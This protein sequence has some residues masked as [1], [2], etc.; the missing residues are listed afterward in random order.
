MGQRVVELGLVGA[1][2]K[3]GR[4]IIDEIKRD[5]RYHLQCAVINQIETNLTHDREYQHIYTDKLD[6]LNKSNVVMDFSSPKSTICTL[7]YCVEHKLPLVIGTTGFTEL[8]KFF[9]NE[10]ATA[11]PILFSPNMSLSVNILFE[12]VKLVANKLPDFDVEI[13]ETHHRYKKD[14]PSG[15]ALK[16]GEMVANSRNVSLNEVAKFGRHGSNEPRNIGEIGFS[17]VRGG[18]IV[19]SHDVKFINDGEILSLKSEINN[20]NSF[21]KGALMAA[22]FIYNKPAGLYNMKDVLGNQINELSTKL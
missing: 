5:K 16:L 17:V 18:D 14:A 22:G 20:R 6:K 12:L 13:I 15:T 3:M 4:C 10:C 7:N 2:G 8:E 11:I 21:A 9:I 19:G 1:N